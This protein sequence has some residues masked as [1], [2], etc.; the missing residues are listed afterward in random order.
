MINI[1]TPVP[2]F[3]S[4]TWLN[5]TLYI[6]PSDNTFLLV[7]LVLCCI[8]KIVSCHI[9]QVGFELLILLPLE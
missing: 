1:Q 5:L 2:V 4:H 8:L 3:Q 7:L 9:A 6:V